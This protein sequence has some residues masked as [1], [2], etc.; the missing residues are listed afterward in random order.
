MD[1]TPLRLEDAVNDTCPYTGGPV[2][3]DALTL[4]NGAV[5]GFG[6]AEG[7]DRFEAAIRHFEAALQTRRMMSAGNSE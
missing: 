6:D 3:A 7:R 5:V 4:Y 2:A 1:G